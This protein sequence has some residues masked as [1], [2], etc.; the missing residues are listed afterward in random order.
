MA[1]VIRSSQAIRD[2]IEIIE[3][4]RARWGD[5]TARDY[6]VLIER[7]LQTIARDPRRGTPRDDVRPGIL[8]YAVRQRGRRARHVLIYRLAG[9]DTVEIA[10]VL[11]DA[12]D[13][14]QHV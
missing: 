1:R 12:M 8:V 11:H 6:L 13:F 2:V 7:A 14:D 10:R 5:A 3:Y 9:A 4:T